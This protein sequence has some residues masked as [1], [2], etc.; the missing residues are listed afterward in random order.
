MVIS[1]FNQYPGCSSTILVGSLLVV[2]YLFA[3]DL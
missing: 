3:F 1:A 2:G